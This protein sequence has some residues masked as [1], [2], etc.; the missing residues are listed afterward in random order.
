MKTLIVKWLVR[1]GLFP[2]GQSSWEKYRDYI[3]IHPTAIIA[4]SASVK[5]FNLPVPPRICLEIG[6]GSHIFS[7]FTLLRPE[8]T[9]RV[10]KRT[11]LGNSSFICVDSIEVGDDVLMA[12][13]VTIMD[14]DSHSLVWEERKDDATRCYNDYLVDSSNFICNKDW[15]CVK[16]KPIIIGNKSWIG[17]NVS[18][19]K[20]VEIGEGAVVGAASLVNK[21]VP[22][23]C[24]VAGNP[25]RIVRRNDSGAASCD[26]ERNG[27]G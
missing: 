12:W 27:N 20:G 2:A 18:L 23:Y 19:L 4:P 3:R 9:I 17:F 22:S 13:G 6:E 7:N 1:L 10:G 24:V 8:A 14:N 21:S 11:Q 26:Q 25:A 5:I 15:N 16:M